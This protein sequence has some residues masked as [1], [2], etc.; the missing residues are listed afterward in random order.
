MMTKLNEV[1]K[2]KNYGTSRHVTPLEVLKETVELIESGKINPESILVVDITDTKGKFTVGVNI[3]RLRNCDVIVV[4]EIVK[5]KMF[6]HIN[7]E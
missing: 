4:C 6:R 2:L 3:S 1:A 5:N 7:G